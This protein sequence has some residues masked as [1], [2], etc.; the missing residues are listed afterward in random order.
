[1]KK[2]YFTVTNDLVFDQRM[3]RICSSLGANG[4]DITLVGR[5]L[6]TSPPL[7]LKNFKQHRLRCFNNKGFLFYAEYNL[8]LFFY[9]LFKRF[10]A[11][12]A[13]DL[14]TILPC[15]L[16]SGLKG[17]RRVYDAHEYF[18]ELKEVRTR[19]MVKAVWL[20]VER[21]CVPQFN[22]GYT[23]GQQIADLFKKHYGKEY[24]V[25]RN[26]PV[27]QNVAT[28]TTFN[29]YL[30]YGGAVNEARGFEALIPAMKK[31]DCPLVIAGDGNF[32]PQLKKLIADCGVH[33]K[34]E[35]M[36][37]VSPQRLRSLAANATL[38]IGLTEKEGLNQ[39]FALPNKFFDYVHALLPQVT[40]NFPEYQE[41]NNQYKVAVL[42]DDVTVDEIANAVNDT[43]ANTVLLNQ[44]KEA[45]SAAREKHNWQNEEKTLLQFYHSLFAKD[46]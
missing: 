16:V 27:L 31:I 7:E 28:P 15:L 35:L 43:M 2:L 14:D 44:M 11:V 34:V 23:V 5:K 3:H 25:I 46:A 21:F 38:G 19:P 45:C 17:T 13:I 9:L 37:M 18:T 36:G 20:A 8:R 33:Q 40:M 24:G 39:Y 12:C 41:I 22:W 30:F 6:P 4:Y 29:N 10:D 26:V 1:L 42:I 32:M